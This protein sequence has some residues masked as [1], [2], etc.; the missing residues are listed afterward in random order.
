MK[1]W[2]SFGGALAGLHADD[3]LAAAALRAVGADVGAL[4]QAA[5]RDGDDDAFVGDQVLDGDL[6]FVGHQLGQAR[7]GVLLLDRRSSSL[8][9]ASTRASR[10]RMS[11]RSLMRSS[12]LAVFG[13]DLVALQAGELVEAQFEDGIDLRFAEGVAAAGQA[14]LAADQDAE[15]LDLRPGELEGEQLDLGLLAVRRT[16][17]DADELVEVGQRDQVAFEQS[18]RAPRPCA[19]RTACGGGRLRGGARCSS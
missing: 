10:A 16:A 17:D 4:D 18:R 8:M 19:A 2:S 9:M 6:A 11:S 3:A 12:K 1:S 5:V 14:R 15:L 13:P 7:R